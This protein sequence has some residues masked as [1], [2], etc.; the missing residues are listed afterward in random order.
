M[1]D[2]KQ[3]ILLSEYTTFAVGG[4]ADFF[5]EV[6]TTEDLAEA[7]KFA[8]EHQL[9]V[10]V[11]GGGSNMVV[12]DA[13]IRGMV[14]NV[15]L[16]GIEIVGENNELV[17]IKVAAGEQWD[18]FVQYAVSR[19]Y[20]GVENLS[21]IPGKTGAIA[22]QNVGAYGQE[23]SQVIDSV[24]AHPLN[25]G[26]T[27][28]QVFR[29]AD[30]EFAYRSSIFNTPGK[31]KYVITVITFSL[32]KLPA[33]N[34]SYGDVKKYFSDLGIETPSIEQIRTA[35][36]SIRDKKFPYPK[37]PRGGSSGSF[38]KA[39]TISEHEYDR[40]I[41]KVSATFGEQATE[42]LRQIKDRLVV[43]QGVKVPYGYLIELCGLKGK[44][45]ENVSVCET[46][47]GVLLNTEGH[48]KAADV[49]GAFGAIRRTVYQKTGI[50]LQNEP[51]L[52]GFTEAE[53]G[54]TFALE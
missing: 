6:A 32:S 15:N 47:A 42:K 24:E 30:C 3:N 46:H 35:I 31:N 1:I 37:E 49:L 21:H 5:V 2:I 22:V 7:L 43:P 54:T 28:L 23:A 44:K 14:I 12:S 41:Q 9:P 25:V 34:T 26:S 10:T 50:I 4:P 16:A 13:G 36:I 8:H 27:P 17:K 52:V 45:F 20:W 53:L 51:E 39:H 19:G 38:F 48:A 33:P 40:L 18:S 11:L 29:N